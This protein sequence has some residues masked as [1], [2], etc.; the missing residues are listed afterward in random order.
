[1]KTIDTN[2]QNSSNEISV[3]YLLIDSSSL[4]NILTKFSS[5]IPS[6]TLGSSTKIEKS[7]G[8]SNSNI[9]SIS[10]LENIAS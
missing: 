10:L 5:I 4:L 9:C 3:Y 1:M 2:M 8:L 6:S 7:A